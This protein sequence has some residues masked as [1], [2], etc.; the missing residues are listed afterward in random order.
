MADTLPPTFGG[1]RFTVFSDSPAHGENR[2]EPASDLAA[3]QAN[4]AASLG[5]AEARPVVVAFFW[6]AAF[7]LSQL[8]LNL[9]AFS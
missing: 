9:P 5:A 4:R 6:L 7:S 8:L 3:V 2:H 1:R